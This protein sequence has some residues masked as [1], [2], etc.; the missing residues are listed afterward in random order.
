M[1]DEPK[2]IIR[3]HWHWEQNNVLLKLTR[4]RK[5]HER[6]KYEC[7]FSVSSFPDTKHQGTD[8]YFSKCFS[9]KYDFSGMFVRPMEVQDTPG[10]PLLVH[11]WP[12]GLLTRSSRLVKK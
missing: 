5:R 7:D 6:K 11:C 2:N 4:E 8:I 10:G 3:K 9:N 1:S 12:A